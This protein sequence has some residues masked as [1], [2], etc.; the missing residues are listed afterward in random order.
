[1]LV[2]IHYV[3]EIRSIKSTSEISQKR[4]PTSIYF[5]RDK[6]IYFFAIILNAVA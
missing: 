6:L 5:S 1:M 4:K 2:S 3:S